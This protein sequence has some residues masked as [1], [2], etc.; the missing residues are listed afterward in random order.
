MPTH[1]IAIVVPQAV[2]AVVGGAENLWAGLIE[3]LNRMQGIS[4]Q[5]VGLPSHEK[6]LP[7]IL[8]TYAAFAQLDLS[9]FDQVIS[10]KYPAWAIQHPNHT[11]YLQHTL[12][13]L[14]DTYPESLGYAFS[15]TQEQLLAKALP[16]TLFK[17]LT[18]ASA[19]TW[20]SAL[21]QQVAD[22]CFAEYGGIAQ[23]ARSL[24]MVTQSHASALSVFPGNFSRACVRLLDAMAFSVGR[25]NQFAAISATVAGRAD[26]F[27]MHAQVR[28]LHHPSHTRISQTSAVLPAAASAKPRDL[29]VTASRLEHPKRIDLLLRAYAQSGVPHPFWVIGVGPQQEELSA[30]AKTIPG[31]AMKGRLSDEEL[32]SAYQRALFIPFIPAQEDYGLITVEAFLAGAAVLT[33]TDAGGPTEL[34]EHGKN[35]LIAEPTI[36][37]IAAGFRQLSSHPDQTAQM[38]EHGRQLAQAITWPKLLGVLIQAKPATRKKILV[39]NT[40]PTEPVVSGGSLRMKGF[41]T[42][43]SDYADIHMLSLAAPNTAARGRAHNPRFIEEIIPAEIEFSK[44]ERLLSQRLKASCGDLAALLYP[45]TLAQY[46]VAIASELTRADE[47]VFSHPYMFTLYEQLIDQHPDLARPF[48]YEA[49]NVESHLKQSIYPDAKAELH[50]IRAVEVR[51]IKNAKAVIACSHQDLVSFQE[52]ASAHGFSI[53]R[54]LVAE[55]GLDLSGIEP[56][57]FL[58]RERD[59]QSRGKRIALFMGSDHGPNQ[60]ALQLIAQ[61]ASDPAISANWDFVVLGSV[62]NSFKKNQSDSDSPGLHLVGL[63]SDE[64]KRLWL[65]VATV[66]LNPI[67]SGSG[68]NLKLAEYAAHGLPVLSTAFGARGGLWQPG[69]HYLEITQSLAESLNQGVFTDPNEIQAMT[70]RALH[71]VHQRLHWPVIAKNLAGSL[72]ACESPPGLSAARAA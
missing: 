55:N 15:P 41:Y 71:L 68:T 57:S 42:A 30:L 46:R 13:G 1:R 70:E 34:V 66:G 14:Y 23:V 27:P 12:R 26:Y 44:K 7:E 53:K 60:Q 37:S 16:A 5:L 48:I 29:I 45:E 9:G 40:F 72:W 43:L 61:A 62:V 49:H 51:L 4:A 22:D 18:S 20:G 64:E 50:A 8:E 3:N 35:G 52:L 25:V 28:V 47:V 69:M 33:T 58:E 36:E 38:G 65:A 19:N 54:P 10:T 24:L 56:R 67:H 2:P 17:S 21:R 6:T 11:V 32:V 59:A 31:V 63:V 39:L